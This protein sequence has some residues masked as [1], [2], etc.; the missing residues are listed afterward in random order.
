MLTQA[1][2]STAIK[3]AILDYPEIAVLYSAGDPRI[4]ATLNAQ[5]IMLAMVSAQ[6]EHAAAEPFA[7]SRDATVLAGAAQRGIINKGVS[8]LVTVL[9]KNAT[10]AAITVNSGDA[11]TDVAGNDY[12][13]TTGGVIPAA[14]LVGDATVIGT[15]TFS[16]IQKKSVE[17]SHVVTANEPFYKIEIPIQDGLV[18]SSIA[19]SDAVNGDYEYRNSFV[20]TASGEFAYHVETD[21]KQRI[22]VV[23]G[24]TGIAGVQPTIGQQ[25][26]LSLVYCT[27][28]ITAKIGSPMAFNGVSDLDLSLDTITSPG[29][30]PLPI[31]TLR[32][33][34]KY[35]A[36]YDDSAVFLGEFAFLVKRNF[37]LLK[38][39]SVWNES[40]EEVVRGMNV[41]NVNSLFIACYQ[42]TET[43][44][45]ETDP[46][47]QVSPTLI[48]DVDLTAVQVSIK[49][50]VNKSDSS[51]RVK[52]YTPV[53]AP[54]AMAVTATISTSYILTNTR[55]RIKA[56]LLAEYGIDS[57][58]A[59]RKIKPTERHIHALLMQKV[60]ELADRRSEL[61]I[62]ITAYPNDNR[63]E[64]FRYVTSTSLTVSVTSQDSPA[65]I[66]A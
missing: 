63:P 22:Y 24:L 5:A 65:P 20:N 56:I 6:I 36:I 35:P 40:V 49:S 16:A 7:M 23:F 42:A 17:I 60:P 25:I 14:E 18:I 54:I 64:L 2:F 28:E 26:D 38:F 50:I 32:N 44:L 12:I 53:I 3:N 46:G 41:D 55:D 61:H 58:N 21:E 30:N 15:G 1:D 45:T 11:L 51:Y 52:F 4:I 47:S 31:T 37:P 39:V 27:G 43:M 19:V 48:A 29:Q 62:A 8:A 13:A 57:D 34:C 59:K 9:A 10:F 66:W 33:L